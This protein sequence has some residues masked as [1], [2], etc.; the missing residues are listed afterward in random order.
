MRK[1][2][3]IIG[4]LVYTMVLPLSAQ[5]AWQG[6]VGVPGNWTNTANWSGGVLPTLDD[7]ANLDNGGIAVID[8]AAEADR[9]N[10]NSGKLELNSGGDLDVGS[11]YV[12]QYAGSDAFLEVDGGTYTYTNAVGA[13]LNIGYNSGSTGKVTVLSGTMNIDILRLGYEGTGL[14]VLSNGTVTVNS[15]NLYLTSIG[16][17]PN[18]TGT[19]IQDGGT[20]NYPNTALVVGKSTGS[21]G[22]Y[23]LNDGVANIDVI[24][25]GW[26]S[27]SYGEAEF[28]G[29]S[30]DGEVYAGSCPNGTGV[31]SFINTT[32]TLDQL[33]VNC[34]SAPGGGTAKTNSTAILTFTDSVVTNLAAGGHRTYMGYGESSSSTVLQDGGLTYWNSG[35]SVGYS[36]SATATYTLTNGAV[37]KNSGYSLDIGDSGNGRFNIH[38]GDV[39]TEL[40]RLQ[41]GDTGT[42]VVEITEGSLTVTALNMPESS[43][44]GT[45]Y[46][47]AVLCWW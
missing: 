30:F 10:I 6:A 21:R 23:V 19:L 4:L 34:T 17:N 3:L 41:V 47:M 31:V 37:L 22:R 2:V 32:N 11:S 44:S 26:D 38:G 27:G 33:R 35:I 40:G 42:G 8:S 46:L 28:R 45:I 20:L 13:D 18:S 1:Y 5:M 36:P 39:S 24:Y 29:G 25:T 43:G 12:G 16:T 7:Y 15:G 9:I 14:F